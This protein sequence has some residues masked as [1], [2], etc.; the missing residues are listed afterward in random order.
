MAEQDYYSIL[1]VDKQAPERE[2]KRA[3]YQLARD[4]HPDK[5]KSQEEAR[6]HADQLAVISKAYNTLKDP[7]KRAEYDET[8][9]KGKTPSA[10][11]SSSPACPPGVRP[12]ANPVVKRRWTT[13]LGARIDRGG[14]Q[15]PGCGRI[16]VRMSSSENASVTMA[17]LQL[18][19]AAALFSSAGAAIKGCR[20]DGLAVVGGRSAIAALAFL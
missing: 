16:R 14:P 13:I 7:R 5:A 2:I 4:L 3:Y 10:S 15:R 18:L 12:D 8:L 19:A 1:G 11:A 17:R 9:G 20:L 6:A